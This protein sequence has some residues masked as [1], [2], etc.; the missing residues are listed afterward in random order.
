MA[1]AACN[2][3]RPQFPVTL[4]A[5]GD[6][7]SDIV[8]LRRVLTQHNVPQP[9][10][11][12]AVDAETAAARAD[13]IGYPVVL[14]QRAGTDTVTLRADGRQGVLAGYERVTREVPGAALCRPAVVVEEVLEGACI[15]VDIAVLPDGD[16]RIVAITRT[17]R[18]QDPSRQATRHTVYTHDAL[19]H[20][21]VLRRVVARTVHAL[22]LGTGVLR[23][24]MKLTSRGP[25]I[26][27]VQAYPADDVSMFL[28]KTATGIDLV[29]AAADLDAGATPDLTATRQRAAAIHLA[30][31][32]ATGRIERSSLP[33][34]P[35]LEPFLDHQAQSQQGNSRVAATPGSATAGPLAYWIVVRSNP[36]NCHTVLDQMTHKSSVDIGTSADA[37]HAARPTPRPCRAGS[38]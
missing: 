24:G 17:T 14:K 28:I 27:D 10:W 22:V 6:A 37:D 30:Y 4:A 2:T 31:P 36:S 7:C 20:N 8:G 38:R 16:I 12:E 26:I 23:I 29:Q 25:R 18:I 3:R 15:C 19:L 32:P 5:L 9:R 34:E 33:A 11:S 1:T 21:P 13:A 35:V